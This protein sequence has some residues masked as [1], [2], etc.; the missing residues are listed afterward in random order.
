LI[1]KSDMELGMSPDTAAHF[2]AQESAIFETEQPVLNEETL[3]VGAD[4]VRRWYGITKVPLYDSE[5]RMTGLVGV[6]RDV[7]ERKQFE[8]QLRYHASLLENVS[9]A[10]IS[11]DM[12]FKIVS[13]NKG[14]EEIYGW[15]AEEVI[16]KPGAEI[17]AAEYVHEESL[18]QSVVELLENGYWTGEVMHPHRDGRKLHIFNVTTLIKDDRGEFVG[19]VAVNRDIT[20]RRLAEQQ[21]MELVVERERVKILQQV[22]SDMSHDLK[23]PLANFR[24]SLYLLER[25]IDNPARRRN[26]LNALDSHTTRLEAMLDDLLS[27]ARLEQATDE[28]HFEQ[29]QVCELVRQLVADQQPLAG[30]RNQTLVM[31]ECPDLPNIQAD[32][33]KLSRAV[34]NLVMNAL[35]YTP[36]EGTVSVGVRR[37]DRYL[38]IDVRDNG[39]GISREDQEMIFER[40]Y[41]VDK[42]R[43]SATGGTGLGL[44]ITRR[45]VE[46]HRGRITVESMPGAGSLF[47]I[48]LPVGE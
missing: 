12:D 42:A 4:G 22:I 38:V 5:G 28:F 41:R 32:P 19:T 7:T 30:R 24:T 9:D 26:Y 16:G 10:V 43:S 34:T 31:Q 29:L 20:E 18:Q 2:W 27:M 33:L 40:F 21:E 6:N 44:S 15:R 17:I 47:S 3:V 35:N 25:F 14:A 39:I 46:A 8:E 48:W 11:T 45:I 36:E 13:W 1:G 23:N 37:E